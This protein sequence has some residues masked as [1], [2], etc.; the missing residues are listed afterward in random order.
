IATEIEL[1]AEL[2]AFDVDAEAR[3]VLEPVERGGEVRP[4]PGLAAEH[5]DD[6]EGPR[7]G[8]R[9]DAGIFLQRVRRQ[10]EADDAVQGADTPV[11]VISNCPARVAQ[12][13]RLQ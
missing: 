7:P 3:R 2:D 13:S 6:E 10:G 8:L 9:E 11:P 4:E 1:V 5:V 12:V